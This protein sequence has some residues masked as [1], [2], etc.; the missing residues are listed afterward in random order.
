MHYSSLSCMLLIQPSE[1]LAPV[2]INTE[3]HIAT[4]QSPQKKTA[5]S[6]TGTPASRGKENDETLASGMPK[7]SHSVAD[8][9]IDVVSVDGNGQH[10][11]ED[12]RP[13]RK[14][15]A[16]VP[17][18]EDT[19][20]DTDELLEKEVKTKKKI[21]AV[22]PKPAK[23]ARD[24]G[25]K[26]VKPPR[27]TAQKTKS[28]FSDDEDNGG[29]DFLGKSVEYESYALRTNYTLSYFTL[30]PASESIVSKFKRVAN[31]NAKLP[32][33]KVVLTRKQLPLGLLGNRA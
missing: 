31:A 2:A 18:D 5:A 33:I 9:T 12:G 10:D 30:A 4:G 7:A 32:Y 28:A 1:P 17:Y 8:E 29:N 13:V 25:P 24:D 14:R 22:K 15:K 11:G 16:T 19:D 3:P 26:N 21:A 23:V 6:L 20:M 27:K